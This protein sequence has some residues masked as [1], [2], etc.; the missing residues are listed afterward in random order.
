MDEVRFLG[1]DPDEP[2]EP[3]GLAES[4]NYMRGGDPPRI[5]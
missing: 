5:P 2:F 4:A 3:V 1:V